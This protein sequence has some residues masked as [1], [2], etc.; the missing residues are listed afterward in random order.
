MSDVSPSSVGSFLS[1]L[2][3]LP[4]WML[5]GLALAGYAVLFAPAFGG[6][7]PTGFRH[8]WGIWFWIEALTFSIL[9][10]AR[11]LDAGI[12]SHRLR[13]DTAR[14]RLPL[15][16]I[17]LH[18][19]CW[20]HLAKQQDDTF[21]SQIRLDVEAANLTDGPVRIVKVRLIRPKTKGEVLNADASLPLAGSPYHSNRHA[22][23]PHDTVTA[24][25]HLMVRGALAQQGKS[26]TVTLGITDQ[27][28]DEYRLKGILIRTHD[29]LLPKRTWKEVLAAGVRAIPLLRPK[30]QIDPPLP[31]VWQHGGEFQEADL[32]LN[33]EKR[34]YAA[35]GRR[36]GGLGSLNI[37]LQSDPNLSGTTGGQVPSLL[38]DKAHAKVIDSP[39][40]ARL[41]K[42]HDTGKENL[43]GY[44]L[45]HLH[46]SSPYADVGYAIFLALHRMDRTIDALA[47]ARTHL[48]GDKVCGY[49]NLLGTFSAMISYEH[50]D[51]D[52]VLYLRI[53]KTLEGDTEH[54][55]KLGEKIN[56]ARL[57]HLDLTLNDRGV[58]NNP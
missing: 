29:P 48:S 30:S 36:V 34:A 7:D 37:G 4:V 14:S 15:R 58:Q 53:L 51:I 55:F 9:A 54:N 47:A 3:T 19:Q 6:V 16:L 11:G 23:P 32:I 12:A 1:I 8:Q 26:I 13:R 44:L 17:P 39:N 41:M 52:P 35:H 43:E 49:S 2:R 10:V 21:V 42:L 46:R 45:S 38:W 20:W 18:Q 22:V 24:A 33:E 5:S 27:F 50:F 31:V 28:G 56:E 25:L 40:V 57:Q